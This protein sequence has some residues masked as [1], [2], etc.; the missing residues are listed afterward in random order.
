MYRLTQSKGCTSNSDKCLPLALGAGD[1]ERHLVRFR[2]ARL[3]VIRS[4]KVRV[5]RRH[6]LAKGGDHRDATPTVEQV[7]AL[8]PALGREVDLLAVLK[9]EKP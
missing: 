1:G 6:I 8:T 3:Y 2:P 9:G 5:E 4:A 7:E